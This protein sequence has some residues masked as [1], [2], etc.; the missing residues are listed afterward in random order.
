[1]KV[2]IDT[3]IFNRKGLEIIGSNIWN[4]LFLDTL[5]KY[6]KN[7]MDQATSTPLFSISLANGWVALKSDSLKGWGS[8]LVSNFLL[9]FINSTCISKASERLSN[10]IAKSIS[11]LSLAV[12]IPF[13]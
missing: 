3:D 4:F 1:M 7:P 6:L 11:L 12:P 5:M 9:I 13:A 8:I 2:F 10:M